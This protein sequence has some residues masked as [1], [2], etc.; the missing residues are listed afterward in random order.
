MFGLQ[1]KS[2]VVGAVLGALVVPKLLS[3][4]ASRKK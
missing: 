1:T 4:V 2:V 3:L